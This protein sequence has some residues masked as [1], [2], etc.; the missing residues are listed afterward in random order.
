MRPMIGL[1]G[2][3]L[4]RSLSF[5][6]VDSG[7]LGAGAGGNSTSADGP[8]L[9][10]R[11]ELVPLGTAAR[12]VLGGYLFGSVVSGQLV[13][14]NVRPATWAL[15]LTGFPALVLVWHAWRVRRHPARF[16]DDS[17][18]SFV[19]GALLLL[20]LYFD[21]AAPSYSEIAERMGRA[22]GGIGPMR[23]RCLERLRCLVEED[24]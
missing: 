5:A 22:I 2:Q 1:I 17:P 6:N 15:G 13:T 16:S 19:I 14:H 11:R 24:D 18:L 20:A 21:P 12:L 8:T 9:G 3:P 7:G 4:W 10:P 23:A